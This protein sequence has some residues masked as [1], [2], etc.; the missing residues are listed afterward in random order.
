M[1]ALEAEAGALEVVVHR[2][3]GEEVAVGRELDAHVL[4]GTC[5]RWHVYREPVLPFNRVSCVDVVALPGAELVDRAHRDRPVVRVLDR[6]PLLEPGA[7]G[8]FPEEELLRERRRAHYAVTALPARV[9][10]SRVEEIGRAL[11]DDRLVGLEGK[12][13]LDTLAQQVVDLERRT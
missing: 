1:T 6:Q 8:P 11:R 12:R 5:L 3:L 13:R 4:V 7:R 10:P 2:S 9:I